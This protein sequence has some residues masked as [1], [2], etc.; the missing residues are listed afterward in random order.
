VLLVVHACGDLDVAEDAIAADAV[1]EIVAEP[2][3]PAGGV[4]LAVADEDAERRSRARTSPRICSA[5]PTRSA[6]TAAP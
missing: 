1:G 2:A 4:V 5:S 6:S 3:R